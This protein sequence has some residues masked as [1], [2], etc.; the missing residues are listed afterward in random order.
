[1][2]VAQCYHFIIHV[3]TIYFL[4]IFNLVY[5][6]SFLTKRKVSHLFDFIA[7]KSETRSLPSNKQIRR[8]SFVSKRRGVHGG[9]GDGDERDGASDRD[10]HGGRRQESRSAIVDEVDV[11]DENA[12]CVTRAPD[13]RRRIEVVAV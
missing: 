6:Y 12:V 9:V 5:K 13:E 11:A 2:H 3:I 8:R 10:R 4:T 1:M 7:G